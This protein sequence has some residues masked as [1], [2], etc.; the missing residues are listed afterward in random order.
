M[1]SCRFNHGHPQKRKLT[2]GAAMR[3]SISLALVSLTVAQQSAPASDQPAVLE[4]RVFHAV[5]KE[6][7]RK[8]RVTLE[9]SEPDHDSALVATTDE[10]G[11]FR[12]ADVKP[13]HYTI[14]AEK[15]GFLDENYYP[16][17][18]PATGTLLKVASGDQMKDLNVR[19]SPAASISGKVLDSDGDPVPNEQVVLLEPSE[20][21][22]PN[23]GKRRG[24]HAGIAET[25][26]AGEYRIHGLVPGAYYVSASAG[27]WGHT[28]KQVPVDS[29]GRATR[30]HDL[31]TFY[32]AAVTIANAQAVGVSAGQELSGI[33]I[34]IQRGPTL[35][36]K[37]TIAGLAGAPSK[38]SLSA[39]VDEGLGFTSEAGKILA[40]GAF[41]FAELPP[42]EHSLRLF[43][44]GMNGP[45]IIAETD[46]TLTDQDLT[47]VVI[48]PFK[49]ARVS[50]RA[51]ME[52][53]ED[54]PLTAG[55]VFL[56]PANGDEDFSRAIMQYQPL[57]GAYI[58][59]GVP[60]G[61]YRPWFGIASNCYLK[62][63]RSGDRVLDTETVDVTEGAVIDLLL[64]FS[65]N[66]ASVTGDV[67]VSQEQATQ[68]VHVILV[69]EAPNGPSTDWATLDQTFHFTRANLRPGK[70]LALAVQ[71]EDAPW[72]N[73]EFIRSFHSEGTELELREN[74][75]ATV[76]L[77]LIPK[78]ETDDT[79][80]RLG[81]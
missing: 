33:D 78:E 61:Q 11:H 53:E 3:V 62:S 18:A 40:N 32:P 10:M 76:H 77:K 70:Y 16:L 6:P 47:G 35:S 15:A 60:P 71:D 59:E 55:S 38:Y 80:K 1:A 24:I 44:E 14:S 66:V 79:R 56:R 2:W 8:A 26:L 34:R 17:T 72:K 51:V 9:S 7:L 48:T 28:P 43:E 25:N 54:R 63:V 5:T 50:V 13:G 49:P 22:H 4:G 64:T 20:R 46:V 73:P 41:A 36:V 39:S 52:G 12:F 31:M 81:L 30:L 69:Q 67:E 27:A 19:L 57:N 58:L 74:E 45:H 23:R 75:N 21:D 68:P 29:T 37:G 65:K 42:G